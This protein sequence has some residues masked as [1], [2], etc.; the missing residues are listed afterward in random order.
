MIKLTGKL[1]GVTGLQ[2]EVDKL[3]ESVKENLRRVVASAA[4]EVVALAHTY[5]NDR[6]GNLSASLRAV[7]IEVPDKRI[8]ARI[9]TDVHYGRYLESGWTPNP[10]RKEGWQRNPRRARDWQ[11]YEQ[12]RGGRMIRAKPFLRPAMAV[13]GPSIKEQLKDAVKKIK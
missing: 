9:G 11:A 7:G 12:Q 3:G 2:I 4:P 5:I 10:R 13:L 8:T 6:S 1:V